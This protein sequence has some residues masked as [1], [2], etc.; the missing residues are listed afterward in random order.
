MAHDLNTICSSPAPERRTVGS[1]PDSGW[2]PALGKAQVSASI[3]HSEIADLAPT[4]HIRVALDMS[5]QA[6]AQLDIASG[7]PQGVAV[8]LAT[9][10]GECLGLGVEFLQFPSAARLLASGSRSTWDIAFM[11]EE[12][13]WVSGLPSTEPCAWSDECILVPGGSAA[14]SVAEVDSHGSRIAVE[15]DTACDRFLSQSLKQAIL[16]RSCSMFDALTIFAWAELEAVAGQRQVL[17]MFLQTHSEYR[18]IGDPFVTHGHRI[19]MHGGRG[20]GFRF[21]QNFVAEVSDVAIASTR[22]TNGRGRCGRPA[23]RDRQMVPPRD[24]GLCS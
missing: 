6:I 1:G 15:K 4:G 2:R 19:V 20:H 11:P 18:L 8:L 23:L 16:Q 21:L 3:R 9:H 10:L 14:R 5:Q 12:D 13:A 24:V 7:L 22:N 17:E